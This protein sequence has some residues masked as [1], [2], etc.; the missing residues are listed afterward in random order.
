MKLVSFREEEVSQICANHLAALYCNLKIYVSYVCLE[1]I[2]LYVVVVFCDLEIEDE[3]VDLQL[4]VFDDNLK[5]DEDELPGTKGIDLGNPLDLF[6]AV[7]RQ[8]VEHQL[9][10]PFLTVLQHLL[11]IDTND[12]SLGETVWSTVEQLVAKATVVETKEDAVKLVTS[13]SRRLEGRERSAAPSRSRHTSSCTLSGE[14]NEPHASADCGIIIAA[15]GSTPAVNG[16]P[17]AATTTTTSE[18]PPPPPPP[19]PPPLPPLGM[20][21]GAPPPPPP[22]PGFGGGP[23]PPP[24]PPFGMTG[25]HHSEPVLPQTNIP[26]PKHKM[27]ALNWQKISV[28]S[29][30]GKPNLWTEVGSLQK[31]FKMDYEKM[32]E[33]FGVSTEVSSKRAGQSGDGQPDSKKKKENMEIN[34]LDGKRSLNVNIFLKQFRISHEEIVQHVRHGRREVFGAE[35]LRSLLKLLPSQEEIDAFNAFDG[36]RERLGNAEKF[37]IILMGLPNYRMRIEGLLIMEEFNTN[38]EWIRPSIEAVIQAARDIQESKSLKELIFLILVSGNYLNSGNYAGNAAGFKLSSLLKLTELRANKPG[39]NL[40]HYVAQEAAEKNA[41]LLKFPE[42]MKFLKDASQVSVETLATDI[43]SITNKV[44]AITDQICLAGKDFQQQM[45]IFLKE[46]NIE[47]AELQED[48]KEI[49]EIRAEMATY[50]CED[51][52]T[53]KLEE[54]FRILQTFCDKL[55][56]AHEENIQRLIKEAKVEENREKRR[57]RDLSEPT[58]QTMERTPATGEKKGTILDVLLADVR[59]GFASSKLS[60]GNFS[61]TKVTKV[62]LGNSPD[63]LNI[64]SDMHNLDSNIDAFSRGGYGRVSQRRKRGDG[65]LDS[66]GNGPSPT[67]DSLAQTLTGENSPM[68]DNQKPETNFERY[69]SLRRRRLERKQKR[70]SLEVFGADRERAPSPSLPTNN[71]AS[72]RQ[73]RDS[74]GSVPS[75]LDR[76]KSDHEP[77][78]KTST[79][80]RTRSWLDRTK[81]D[82]HSEDESE[83]LINRLKQKL[84]R[85]DSRS[86]PTTPT[87]ESDGSETVNSPS[88][89]STT[90]TSRSSTRWRSGVSIAETN[91]PLEPITERNPT[92][93][94]FTTASQVKAIQ[95]TRDKMSNRFRSSLDTNEVNKVLENIE[96]IS[97][98]EDVIRPNRSLDDSDVGQQ[99]FSVSVRKK[100]SNNMGTDID[101]LLKSIEDTGRPLDSIGVAGPIQ[102]TA[103]VQNAGTLQTPQLTVAVVNHVTN[104]VTPNVEKELKVKREM[105]KKRSQLSMEDVKAAM[106]L[107]QNPSNKANSQNAASEDANNNNKFL[108]AATATKTPPSPRRISPKKE[109]KKEVARN[110]SSSNKELSKAA[111]LAGKNKFRS[112]RFGASGSSD[113]SFRARSNVES[114]SV[115]QALKEIVSKGNISRSKSFEEHVDDDGLLNNRMRNSGSAPDTN[116][117]KQAVLRNSSSRLSLDGR[118]NGLYIPGDD[119]DSENK[120]RLSVKS[121]NTSTETI[122]AN[123]DSSPEQKRK[124]SQNSPP[125]N[126]SPQ[127]NNNQRR[128]VNLVP[129]DPTSQPFKRSYSLLDRSKQFEDDSEDTTTASIAKWRLKREKQRRSVYDNVNDSEVSTE[130]GS[131]SSYASSKDE[132]FESGSL[133]QRTSMSSTLEAEYNGVGLR[134]TDIVSPRQNVISDKNLT[135]DGSHI[136][137]LSE[138]DRQCRTEHWTQQTIRA[139]NSSDIS[140]DT[141][142]D[143]S[144]SSSILSPDSGLDTCK[145]DYWSDDTSTQSMAIIPNN[146]TSTGKVTSSK[147]TTAKSAKTKPVPSYMKP[148]NRTPTRPASTTPESSFKRDTPTRTSV[149][150]RSVT[151]TLKRDTTVRASMRAEVSTNSFQRGT[152]ARMSV[153]GPKSSLKL[154]PDSNSSASSPLGRQRTDSNASISSRLST[155][156]NPSAARSKTSTPAPQCHTASAASR[157]SST[158]T[159]RPGA[160]SS[161]TSAS[162]NT[163]KV[164]AGATLSPQSSSPFNRTQSLR[165]TT[166]RKSLSANTK[167]NTPV[168]EGRKGVSALSQELRRSMTPLPS[169]S[170]GRTTPLPERPHSTTPMS[171]SAKAPSSRRSFMAPTAASKAR[172]DEQTPVPPPRTKSLT[173]KASTLT[174]HA[175]LRV[176]KTSSS[177]TQDLT[178]GRKSP[179]V[180]DSS[181]NKPDHHQ[182]LSTVT[183]QAG[184][185]AVEE[186]AN[187]AVKKS[188]SILKRIGRGSMRVAPMNKNK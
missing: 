112:A 153:R 108:A 50:F 133:S 143:I 107:G 157:L 76:L 95:R 159:S 44:R 5:S 94:D 181:F 100:M 117:E 122:P 12:E 57:S 93:D 136:S 156:S 78:S 85:K 135:V 125:A 43:N 4:Q 82:I 126:A 75:S 116:Q 121:A 18:L 63:L 30:I 124:I 130:A 38:M 105:R 45:S 19:P 109:E 172:A 183:E 96:R 33:L 46:A 92:L 39:V 41:R 168:S 110:D 67:P 147:E 150:E 25:A 31:S 22:T 66:P 15:S 69:A 171:Q 21:P 169:E 149:I 70:N 48:L 154:T 113:S 176:P 187:T 161:R 59:S 145:E 101:H 111:K 65:S 177:L 81:K 58:N 179:A 138:A 134:K 180:L 16:T 152:V 84:G 91:S 119:S 102:K 137:G 86:T 151:P 90:P 87:D 166:P 120:S 56:K 10:L 104:S 139:N 62:N 129:V 60:D 97:S 23:P 186:E 51:I 131:R 79:L 27:R 141:V 34:I 99:P 2:K 29:V 42:E 170:N 71:S 61:V 89:L 8:V 28:N 175:S 188:P 88:A 72:V 26:K 1:N 32:D 20:M 73:N 13:V 114:D 146:K 24:P 155:S 182:S 36:D 106:K 68:E 47:V 49:E 184:D 11:K 17:A 98:A 52:S 7:H 144:E 55:K 40:M 174:R 128:P 6:H 9:E 54:F 162:P 3:Q 142:S 178:S 14:E 132:G 53:F 103:D 64:L 83:A 160:T 173:N 158:P 167:L 37:F 123:N 163:V 127:Y 185:E 80:R 140:K 35:K 165:V 77:E 148:I 74:A 115:D 118:R 164:S